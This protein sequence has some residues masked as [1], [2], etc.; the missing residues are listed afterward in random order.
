MNFQNHPF[1]S[2]TL[3]NNTKAKQMKWADI[4][5]RLTHTT[6]EAELLLNRIIRAGA[7]CENI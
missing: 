2:M 4:E 3:L 1:K 7:G 6:G 5:D